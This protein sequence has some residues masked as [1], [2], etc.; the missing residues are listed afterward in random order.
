MT[1]SEA[2]GPMGT[3]QPPAT[4][5]ALTIAYSTLGGRVHDIVLP[6]PRDAREILVLVQGDSPGR[7][8]DGSTGPTSVSFT[9][10]GAAWP[11][12]VTAR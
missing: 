4:A 10:A 8:T 2:G 12:R 3:D 11:G 1:R 7:W 9:L 6:E 5:I